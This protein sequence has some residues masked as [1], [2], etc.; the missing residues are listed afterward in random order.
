[1]LQRIAKSG[2]PNATPLEAFLVTQ[3]L[4]RA[5]HIDDEKLYNVYEQGIQQMADADLVHLEGLL[6]EKAG[7]HFAKRERW[8]EAERY[9]DRAMSIYRHDWGATAKYNWLEEKRGPVLM[10]IRDFE[11]PGA[12]LPYGSTIEVISTRECS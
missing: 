12:T 5:Q 10:A 1:L 9:F 2:C 7:F 4:A 11:Q 8:A 6:N 3:D